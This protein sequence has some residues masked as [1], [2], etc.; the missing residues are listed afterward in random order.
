MY[1]LWGTAHCAHV[2]FKTGCAAPEGLLYVVMTP[3]ASG[4]CT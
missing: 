3:P 4:I 1:G 2:D